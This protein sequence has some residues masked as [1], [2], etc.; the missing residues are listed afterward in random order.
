MSA[1]S[2]AAIVTET[3]ELDGS[4]GQPLRRL[5]V[6]FA[7]TVLGRGNERCKPRRRCGRCAT[8]GRPAC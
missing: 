1:E 3:T 8:P 4:H 7:A 6:S 2:E 5:I